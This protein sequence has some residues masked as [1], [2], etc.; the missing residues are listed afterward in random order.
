MPSLRWGAKALP[1]ESKCDTVCRKEGWAG[2]I[3]AW[4]HSQCFRWIA[5][6]S[7]TGCAGMVCCV[8]P[9][10]MSSSAETKYEGVGKEEPCTSRTLP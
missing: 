4:D 2:V 7:L 10:A 1:L 6:A 5:V 8:C 9:P 3:E